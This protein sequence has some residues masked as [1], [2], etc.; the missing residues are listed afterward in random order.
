[1]NLFNPWPHI[2]ALYNVRVTLDHLSKLEE[3]PQPVPKIT[4]R[5]K[6][7][8]DGTNSAVRIYCIKGITTVTAQSRSRDITP[9]DD[10]FGFAKWVK[11]NEDYFVGLMPTEADCYITIFGEWCGKGVDTGPTAMHQV[12]NKTFAVFALEHVLAGCFVIDPDLLRKQLGVLPFPA[13]RLGPDEHFDGLPRSNPAPKNMLVIDW[14]D[15]ANPDFFMDFTNEEA[16]KA[17]AQKMNEAMLKIEECDPWVKKMFG[18]EGM[19]EGLVF[20]P[21]PYAYEESQLRDPTGRDWAT[22][23]SGAMVSRAYLTKFMF[24]AK[25]EKHRVKAAKTAVEVDATVL[26][27]I[28]IFVEVFVTEPRLKQALTVACEGDASPKNTGKFLKWLTDDIQRE[29]AA[30]IAKSGL[31]W[32]KELQGPIQQAAR[33]WFGNKTRG[34]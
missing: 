2:E 4:Y 9:G 31:D 3:D 23:R 32:K 7:K 14:H 20:Y 34:L 6:V 15:A 8:L 21:M 12:T 27:S 18:I 33:T 19:G 13:E 28:E 17:T 16:V 11:E 24:K 25:G 30:E 26:E 22:Q 1:M 10:N 5:A 29:G